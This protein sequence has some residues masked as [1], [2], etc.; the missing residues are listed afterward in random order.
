MRRFLLLALLLAPSALAETDAELGVMHAV[1]DWHVEHARHFWENEVGPDRVTMIGKGDHSK[2]LVALDSTIPAQFFD[3]YARDMRP[4]DEI[5]RL[6]RIRKSPLFRTYDKLSAGTPIEALRQ[7]RDL[8]VLPKARIP[9]FRK[10]IADVDP[11]KFY[12]RY[13]AARG[14]L[15]LSAPAVSASGDEALVYSELMMVFSQTGRLFYL[16]KR[17]GHWTIEWSIELYSMPGC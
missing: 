3:G 15:T 11:E 9:G 2:R 14:L 1:I 12:E 16:K 13:R 5:E 8:L 7:R 4:P 6:R 17:A 10:A